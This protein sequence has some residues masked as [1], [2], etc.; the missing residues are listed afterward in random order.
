LV[1]RQDAK[2]LR[3]GAATKGDDRIGV[4][5]KGRIGVN[6]AAEALSYAKRIFQKMNDSE[7]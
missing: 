6:N 5:A 4:S 3:G 2:T 7:T 1:S